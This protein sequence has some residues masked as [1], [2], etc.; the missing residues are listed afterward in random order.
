MALLICGTAR[1][2][3][4]SSEVSLGRGFLALSLSGEL[5]LLPEQTFLLLGYSAS[6][7]PPVTASAESPNLTVPPLNPALTHQ[8]SAGVDHALSRHF[9]LTGTFRFSP[10]AADRVRLSTT[11]INPSLPQGELQLVSSRRSVGLDAGLAYDS[12]GLGEWE[13]GLDGALSATSYGLGR[14]VLAPNRLPL[15][16]EEP[17]W[18]LRPSLG[19]SV[20][21]RLD[22]ELSL[23]AGYFLYSGDPLT[24]GRYT[25]EQLGQIGQSLVRLAG[26]LDNFLR[27]V[28]LVEGRL[29]QA[30]AVSGF[31]A[32]PI[33][34]ELRAQLSHR[35]NRAVKGQL[36][37][38]FD[39][40][41]PT[42]GYAHILSTKWTFRVSE[43]FR[44]WTALALQRDEPWDEASG[45]FSLGGELS[46]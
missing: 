31:A 29:N 22:T 2:A 40:Y 32:A 16:R 6:K 46:F 27:V 37:Y 11:E 39:R 23:R 42:Q 3:T 44:F 10:R 45:L 35:L 20:L 12:G 36:S 13:H 38:A 34:F 19:A 21:F 15:A 26:S 24:T 25:E 30:D 43:A 8:L 5:E 1:A 14:S 18:V 41:V 33:W 9:F 17:L 4:V 7:A 28:E